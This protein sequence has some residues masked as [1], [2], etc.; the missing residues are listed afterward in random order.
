MFLPEEENTS[1]RKRRHR[2]PYRIAGS[3]LNVSWTFLPVCVT[4][5]EEHLQVQHFSDGAEVPFTR[6][7]VSPAD[8]D[9]ANRLKNDTVI[10]SEAS[11]DSVA[12]CL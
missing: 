3:D 7:Y 10:H 8:S 12:V 5:R 11:H 2:S 9:A 4:E 1:C 6:V